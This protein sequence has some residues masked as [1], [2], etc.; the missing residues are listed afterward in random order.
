[1]KAQ[2]CPECGTAFDESGRFQ[3][4][5]CSKGTPPI[6]PPKQV[7]PSRRTNDTKTT[8]KENGKMIVPDCIK[9][10]ADERHIKQYNVRK[11]TCDM[12]ITIWAGRE[13]L[14]LWAAELFPAF[15]FAKNTQKL[16]FL[17]VYFDI[18][19]QKN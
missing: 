12:N 19:T 11:I 18:C 5:A 8:Y 17:I 13:D 3:N 14:I 7:K 4:P 2:F 10:D 9:S 16:N 15:C 6:E 1:M